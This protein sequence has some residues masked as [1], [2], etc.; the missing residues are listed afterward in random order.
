MTN[1]SLLGLCLLG[2]LVLGTLHGCSTPTDDKWASDRLKVSPAAGT[3]TFQGEAVEGATVTFVSADGQPGA[4]A[5]TDS[6]GK[7][8]LTTYEQGDGVVP[9]DYLIRVEKKVMTETV[10]EPNEK[11]KLVRPLQKVEVKSLLPAKYAD[12]KKSGISV[13]IPESGNKNIELSLAE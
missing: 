2:T 4:V 11:N 9:G 7:F 1:H 6:K 12:A 10:I 8:Q 3:V 5:I 13:S